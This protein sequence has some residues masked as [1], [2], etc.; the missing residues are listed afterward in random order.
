MDKFW[1]LIANTLG[2]AAL[3]LLIWWLIA[4]AQWT[5]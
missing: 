2:L 4:V 1:R 3:L 5:V